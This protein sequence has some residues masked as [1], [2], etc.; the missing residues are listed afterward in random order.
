MLQKGK[1]NQWIFIDCSNLSLS[2]TANICLKLSWVPV[3]GT[4]PCFAIGCDQLFKTM[5]S[6]IT[7]P[8]SFVLQT[9]VHLGD[10]LLKCA[11]WV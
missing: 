11:K 3:L 6:L 10:L 4:H 2:V 9:N 7:K 8:D 5:P 1:S